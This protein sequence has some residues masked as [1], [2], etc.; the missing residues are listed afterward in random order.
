MHWKNLSPRVGIAFDL[1]GDG[2]T[3]VKTNIARYVASDNANTAN[4]NDPQKTIGVTDTRTWTD[5]NGDFTII[6]PDGSVQLNELGP[7]TNRNFGKV[8]PTTN[9]QDPSTLDGFG[10]RG[11]SWEYQA[12]V[13]RQLAAR[14]AVTGGY[15]FRWLGNQL[16]TQNTLVTPDSY[17]SPFCI[18]GELCLPA[19]AAPRKDAPQSRTGAARKTYQAAA[20][21][22]PTA[23]RYH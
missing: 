5:F 21:D 10:K 6:N 15:Y 8:I 4:A 23:P 13:Q 7:S 3:A 11:Y 1:F 9:T 19:I 14:V 12:S 18:S 17:S 20:P 16:S 2:K 22:A